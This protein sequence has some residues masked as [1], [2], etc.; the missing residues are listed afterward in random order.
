MLE[1][2]EM[3]KKRTR[4]QKDLADAQLA[5]ELLSMQ[6]IEG[7]TSKELRDAQ[8]VVDALKKGLLEIMQKCL[9]GTKSVR[10]VIGNYR[11]CEICGRPFALSEEQ[12]Y[13]IALAALTSHS[14]EPIEGYLE[15]KGCGL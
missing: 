8:L 13:Y 3:Q 12:D 4:Y 7:T 14:A 5:V 10:P 1:L 15:K 11:I 9:H 6:Q 2:F